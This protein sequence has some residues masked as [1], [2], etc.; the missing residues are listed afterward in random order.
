MNQKIIKGFS[1]YIITSDGDVISLKWGKIK[2]LTPKIQR[3][4]YLYIRIYDDFN[5][6]RSLMLHRIVAKEFLPNE[7]S[8][9]QVNH[10]DG[11]KLNNN[12]KNLE[13][14]TP[15]EHRK[16]TSIIKNKNYSDIPVKMVSLDLKEVVYFDSVLQASK[17]TKTDSSS[18]FKCIKRPS[19]RIAKNKMWYKIDDEIKPYFNKYRT[20]KKIY[21]SNTSN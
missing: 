1:D 16:H 2:K 9:E 5:I 6:R 19:E 8:K 15:T 11:N 4:G 12:V 21:E 3:S 18:I 20:N 14:I 10:I 13:W 7:D 17:I